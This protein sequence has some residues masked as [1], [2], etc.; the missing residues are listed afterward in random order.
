MTDSKELV[1][2]LYW[3]MRRRQCRREKRLTSAIGAVCGLLTLCLVALVFSGGRHSVSTARVYSGAIMLFT[4]AGGYVLTA[5]AAFMA[6]AIITAVLMR[7]RAAERKHNG[8]ED[9]TE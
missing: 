4:N 2:S 5:L 8:S 7:R 6:G 1:S 3:K 9:M